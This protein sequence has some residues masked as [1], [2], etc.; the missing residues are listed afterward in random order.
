MRKI[1]V[2][3]LK[4]GMKLGRS[5]VNASGQMLLVE[6]SI[7]N[8][9]LI[10]KLAQL[11]IPSV[12]VDDGFLSGVQVEDVVSDATRYR[13]I[14]LTRKVFNDFHYTR[15]LS[16][17]DKME[18]IVE[19]ILDELLSNPMVMVNLVDIRGLDEYTFGHSVNTCILS[20]ITAINMGYGPS[21]LRHLG[22]GAI[23][24][25]VGKTLIPLDILSKPGKLT[26]EEFEII[27]SHSELG[28][29]LLT[30]NNDMYPP[31]ALCVLQHH[32]RFDGSGY[33]YGLA[34][35][36]I[37]EFAVIVGV[38]DVYD[39]LTS[40]RVYRKAHSPHE[41]Y[42]MLAATGDYLFDF[43]VVRA[44]LYHVAAYPVGSLVKLSTGV[45]GVVIENRPGYSLRP[46]V[47]VLFNNKNEPVL[48]PYEIDL[49]LEQTITITGIIKDD[50][51]LGWLKMMIC[52]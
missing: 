2:D 31:A 42:E 33:P 17:L 34:G 22:M 46:K 29:R 36:E 43:N 35:K 44:F 49:G 25:D 7:L 47:R 27:K 21:K 9:K 11:R 32:E 45:T 38:A 23:L 52:E 3:R 19:T 6:G 28:Y 12:Y 1:P 10:K 41:A 24:H 14:E 15:C 51:E 26:A 39:A 13:A 18:K 8:D 48:D 5:I 40:D 37:H 4:P 20:L 50:A 16:G 30:R